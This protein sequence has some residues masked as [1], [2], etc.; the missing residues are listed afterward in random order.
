METIQTTDRRVNILMYR[1][2]LLL[3]KLVEA[4]RFATR[5][6]R[7]NIDVNIKICK[8]QLGMLEE[9]ARKKK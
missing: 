3:E 9:A 8:M 5:K 1:I 7:E 6:D 2:R 4:K